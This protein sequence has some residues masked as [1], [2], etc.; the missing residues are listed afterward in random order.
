MD[1]CPVLTEKCPYYNPNI[2][3]QKSGKECPFLTKKCPYILSLH[4]KCP[5]FKNN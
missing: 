2:K 3:T 1:K 4:D 5:H